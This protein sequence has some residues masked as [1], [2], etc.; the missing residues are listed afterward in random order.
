VILNCCIVVSA[1]SASA[2]T[3]VLLDGGKIEIPAQFD[4]GNKTVSYHAWLA[5]TTI[6]ACLFREIEQR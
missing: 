6:W 5:A 4:V 1:S 2:Y 3:I